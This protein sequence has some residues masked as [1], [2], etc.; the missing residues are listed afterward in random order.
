MTELDTIVQK[1]KWLDWIDVHLSNIDELRNIVEI[2]ERKKVIKN[3]VENIEL[4]WNG[5]TKQHTLTMSMKLPL[6]D[7]GISYKKGKSNQFLRDRKSF[8]KYD[9]VEG[10]SEFTTPYLHLNSLNSYGFC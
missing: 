4:N 1:D 6:V 8:K 2:K 3:Y 10:E 5:E 7:D 9:I